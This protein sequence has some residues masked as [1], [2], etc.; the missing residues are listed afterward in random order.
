MTSQMIK[1]VIAKM[2]EGGYS[3][4]E[5]AKALDMSL[6]DF[7]RLLNAW[8]DAQQSW[9]KMVQ[10]AIV[11]EMR[12]GRTDEEIMADLCCGE[13]EIKHS[14]RRL[15]RTLGAINEVREGNKT[16]ACGSC[17]ARVYIS[18]FARMMEQ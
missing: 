6:I 14:K 12:R 11:S 3:I 17:I 7:E 9:N 15:E 13:I 5:G 4:D 8:E 2:L 18:E 10:I 1:E 16:F